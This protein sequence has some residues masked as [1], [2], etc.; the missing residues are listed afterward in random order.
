[1]P[2][3]DEP[4]GEV[5]PIGKSKAVKKRDKIMPVA[6][7]REALVITSAYEMRCNGE[8][9]ATIAKALD[10]KGGW[11][12][13]HRLIAAHYGE[14]VAGID[15]AKI[16]EAEAGRLMVMRAAIES[17][18]KRGEKWAL[19]ADISMSQ[20]IASLMGLND[21][22]PAGNPAVAVQINVAPPWDANEPPP[23]VDVEEG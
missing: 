19:T 2:D 16:R 6:K 8:D 10:I 15:K 22:G 17:D 21:A 3:T 11:V 13:A 1:L 14:L 20:H 12:E 18:V 5:V 9:F 23:Y 4:G 7:V